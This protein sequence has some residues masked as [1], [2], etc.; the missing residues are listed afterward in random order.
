MIG[1]VCTY[2]TYD[3]VTYISVVYFH[4]KKVMYIHV[5][6]VGMECAKF[7]AHTVYRMSVR[8]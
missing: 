4:R 8:L 6:R 7:F 3:T 5:A 1:D 2:N